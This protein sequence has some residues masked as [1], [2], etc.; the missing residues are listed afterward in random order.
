MADSKIERS[1]EDLIDE[2]ELEDVQKSVE[3]GV[4]PDSH[5]YQ[6]LTVAISSIIA[7]TVVLIL[8]AYNLFD[9]YHF[10]Q[11]EQ[12]AYNTEYTQVSTL[13]SIEQQRLNSSG[14][15]DEENG[16]YHIPIDKA[17]ELVAEE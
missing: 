13:K 5:N 11:Q 16:V 15:I 3:I 10:T 17:I 14:I 4:M 6:T 9:Y 12:A 2:Y 8:I 7:I 1:P